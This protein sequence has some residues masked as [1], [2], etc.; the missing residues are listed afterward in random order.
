MKPE[1]LSQ[2]KRLFEEQKRQIHESQRII[3]PE[4]LLAVEELSDEID[5]ASTEREANLRMRLRSR[6]NLYLKKIEEA[7]RR[8][9]EGSFGCCEDCEEE[10]EIKRLEARPTATL[11]VACK[12]NSERNE[13]IFL[14]L[15]G[16]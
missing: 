16:M 3:D 8:I 6:Q 4:L 14:K 9:N 2:F 10:I 12:E 11:C 15:A 13:E 1:T 7:L 5:L